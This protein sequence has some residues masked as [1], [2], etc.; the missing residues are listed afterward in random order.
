MRARGL[1]T[2]RKTVTRWERGV[3]P[4]AAAQAVLRELFE[5]SREAYARTS[6]PRWLPTGAV[7]GATETWD[8]EGT[9]RALDNVTE[10]APVDRR[11]FIVLAGAEILLPV[12]QW[13]LNPGPWIAYQEDGRQVSTALVD[14]IEQLMATRR[15]MDDEHG[16]GA[17]LSALNADLRFI[18]DLLK[19]GSY[20]N[21]TGRRLYATAAEAAR[22][23]GWAAAESGR[24]AAAQSYYLAALRATSAVGDRALGV[25][26]VGFMGT[27]SYATGRLDDATKL[28][29]LAAAESAKTPEA[30][31]AMTWARLGRAYA[32]V[33]DQNTARAAL[34]RAS[35]LLGRAVVGDA[36]PW[37][38]WVDETR[39]SAQLGRA[40]Y[41]MG[42]Y[43]GAERELTAAVASCG[44]RYPRDRA[45]WLGR[46]ATAQLRRG[47][48]DE[49]CM[50]A[51][52]VVDL[53]ADQVDTS[54]GSGLLRT[55]SG[56]L[57]ARG[58]SAVGREFAEYA[59]ARL[60]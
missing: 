29:D 23:A 16:G 22:L 42:D 58:P 45:T 24:Y 12:F 54:R 38:Y 14:E 17:L 47:R 55:F 49:S 3:V 37:A 41:D 6:W 52:R 32:K 43:L 40:L 39:I 44:E 8:R 11:R 26:V 53:L 21:E 19:N 27:L 7:A 4:D 28:M 57:A 13:R 36:P 9:V 25:N 15:R 2:T 56:E 59:T 34:N 50:T 20:Q 30:V 46:V 35:E 48:L 5:V 51:R 33:A 10:E 18:T 60:A 1:G 31:Q